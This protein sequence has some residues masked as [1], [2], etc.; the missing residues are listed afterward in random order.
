M[1]QNPLWLGAIALVI[2]LILSV[3]VHYLVRRQARRFSRISQ[4]NRFSQGQSRQNWIEDSEEKVEQGYAVM[5]PFLERL[6]EA[7]DPYTR[8]HS[9]RV[10]YY[11]RQIANH[12][13][14]SSE[15]MTVLGQAAQLHDLGKVGIPD[16]ILH[17]PDPLS[18]PEWV[19]VKL[20]PE[21]TVEFLR[22]FPF[23][24]QTLPLVRGH[25]ECWNGKG[26]PD[27]LSGENIP[28]GARILSIA[29][30]YDAMTSERPYR[31]RF[32]HQEAIKQLKEG[33]GIQWD[34]RVVEVFIQVLTEEQPP[35]YSR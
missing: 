18:P 22:M 25:H 3:L 6:L 32:S 17:K 24:Q 23:L 4:R 16:S 21:K 20:H 27:G 29:D 14:L 30:A 10:R 35:E 12:L 15:E 8:G 13:A 7:R 34:P 5:V 1:T 19:Q 28:L 9:D 2:L 26:Y 31:P 33:A 11:C